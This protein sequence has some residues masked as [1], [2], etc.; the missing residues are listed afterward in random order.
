MEFLTNNL[1]PIMFGGLIAFLLIGFP[2]AFSLAA[3]GLFFGF[4]GIQLGA[5][6]EALLESELFGYEKGAFTGATGVKRGLFEEAHGGFLFLDEIGEMPLPL[7]VKLLRVLQERKVRRIG[8]SEE[9]FVDVRVI[10][11]TNRNLRERTE[12]NKFREDLYYRLNILHIELPPLR[13]RREDLPVLIDHFLRRSC[14]K[15]N[16]PPMFL[17]SEAMALLDRYRFPGNVRELENLMERCAAL[18]PGGAIGKDVFPDN[19]INDVER[20]PDTPTIT[21]INAS[22][23]TRDTKYGSRT[24]RHSPFTR[25]FRASATVETAT[26]E[27]T[28]DTYAPHI[29]ARPQSCRTR[30]N[31]S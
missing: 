25:T 29:R 14:K 4:I 10:G 16:K 27:P 21:T 1:A 12:A 8:A 24:L 13:D 7:Q 19:L 5:L 17:H 23:N 18:Y 2:V 26:D 30:R 15:L 3:C 6:P 22:D 31:A 20:G 9:K 11:A 28:L